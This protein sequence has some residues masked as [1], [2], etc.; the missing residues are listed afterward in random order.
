MYLLLRLLKNG[1]T[2]KKTLIVTVN[3]LRDAIV[4][5]NF[6]LFNRFCFIFCRNIYKENFLTYFYTYTY[7]IKYIRVKKFK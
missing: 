5:N 6:L 1:I 2:F 4:I 3:H 7:T